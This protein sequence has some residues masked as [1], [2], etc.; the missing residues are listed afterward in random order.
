MRCKCSR[1]GCARENPADHF[2]FPGCACGHEATE[3]GLCSRCLGR[4]LELDAEAR[5]EVVLQPYYPLPN[6]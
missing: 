4:L 1:I 2:N 3:E 5:A 6:R